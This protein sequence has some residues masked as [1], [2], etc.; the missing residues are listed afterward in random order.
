LADVSRALIFLERK[1]G[2]SSGFLLVGHSV[3]ATLSFQ[4]QERFEGFSVPIPIGVLGVE[5][6]Y[7]IP[8]LV[9]ANESITTYRELVNNAFGSD[10]NVWKL[11]SP[12]CAEKPAAWEKAEVIVVAHSDQDELC[13]R[14]QADIMM[15]RLHESASYRERS[16]YFP[17]IGQHDEIWKEGHELARLIGNVLDGKY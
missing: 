12:A 9:K 17:A 2:I 11:A 8:E 5:G 14:A 6:I 3:G 1:Y 10:E 4:I 13:P 7:D 16:H 15:K